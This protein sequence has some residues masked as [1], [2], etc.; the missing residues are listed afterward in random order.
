M[1]LKE[2]GRRDECELKKKKH[3]FPRTNQ[4][5]PV[6]ERGKRNCVD[7]GPGLGQGAVPG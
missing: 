1:K 4:G 7:N 5:P 6:A 3:P 2:P